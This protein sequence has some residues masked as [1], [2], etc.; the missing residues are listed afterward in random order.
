M[1]GVDAGIDNSNSDTK[2]AAMIPHIAHI[3]IIQIDLQFVVRVADGVLG[4]LGQ[5]FPAPLFLRQFA[6][7][8]MVVCRHIA[9]V[10]ATF[11]HGIH[12][13]DGSTLRQCQG[14]KTAIFC[15]TQGSAIQ[16]CQFLRFRLGGF[17]QHDA[18]LIVLAFI[19]LQFSQSFILQ[20]L[21]FFLVQPHN[22]TANGNTCHQQNRQQAHYLF[23][24]PLHK[25]RSLQCLKLYFLEV[26]IPYRS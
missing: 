6:G 1:V 10:L 4:A 15:N 17:V 5:S 9:D 22:D 21:Q 11:L 8:Y 16:L 3:Q 24:V 7:L 26:T 19:A 20:L 2:T 14:R 23:F 18:L 12:I 25:S 13:P